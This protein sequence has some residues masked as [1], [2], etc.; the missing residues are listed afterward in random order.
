MKP[1]I[2]SR[3]QKI[4]ISQSKEKINNDNSALADAFIELI[5]KE[6]EKTIAKGLDI[7][8]SIKDRDKLED[9]LYEM[10]FKYKQSLHNMINSE[11]DN[12][13]IYKNN[14]IEEISK[15]MIIIDKTIYSLNY[16]L[17][18]NLAI[19]KFIIDMW[20]CDI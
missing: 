6:K 14:T 12:S 3:C 7:Y 11:N 8:N 1:T 5:E 16:N 17:N 19:D 18:K 13:I 10:L 4:F 9:V 20:R 2:V 15:K